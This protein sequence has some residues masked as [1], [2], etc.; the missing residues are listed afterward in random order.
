[1]ARR[2]TKILERILKHM[3]KSRDRDS[4]FSDIEEIYDDIAERKGNGYADLWYI[5]QII[6]SLFPMC[7]NKIYRS[8]TMFKNYM[9]IT[10]RNILKHKGYSFINIAG[11]AVG[12][13]CCLLTLQW[14]QYEYSY[15][16]FHENTDDLY[17][18]VFHAPDFDAYGDV[19][20]GLAADFLREEYPEIT[21]STVFGRTSAKL[22][23]N[24]TDFNS[25]G[26]YIHDDFLEMFT[27]PIK[28]GDPDRPFLQRNS[29]LLTEDL[30]ERL[31]GEEDPL[32]KRVR[33]ND[34]YVYVV[35]GILTDIPGNSELQ[36]DYLLS[37]EI[38]PGAMKMWD[39]KWPE[40]Y[41]QLDKNAD[42]NEIDKKI[43]DVYNDHNPGA[44]R[45]DFLLKPLT[46][47][48]LYDLGGGG[49]INYIYVYSAMA[50]VILVIA[51]FNYMNLATARSLNRLNEIGIKKVVGSTR[52]QLIKQFMSESL[53]LTFIAFLI[54]FV[55]ANLLLPAVNNILGRQI[56]VSISKEFIA[57]SV[58]IFLIT[59]L[60]AGS[61]PALFLSSFSPQNI[62][63]GSVFGGGKGRGGASLLR[64]Y[65]VTVQYSLSIIFVISAVVI[66]KQL[67]FMKNTNLGFKKDNVLI[68]QTPGVLGIKVPVLKKELS[69]R[70]DILSTSASRTSIVR[71]GSS[72]GISWPGKTDNVK[73]FDVIYNLVDY[74]YLETFGLEVVEGRFL[75]EEYPTD[76]ED[77]FV[78]NE[79]CVRAMGIEDPIGKRITQGPGTQFEDSREVVGVI[80]DY[81]NRSLHHEIRPMLFRYAERSS[82]LNI[83]LKPDNIQGTISFIQEKVEESAP[84]SQFNYWFL[85]DEIDNLYRTEQTIGVFI[86]YLTVLAI[87]ISSL[88]LLGLTSYTVQ[89]RVK[90]VGIR[91][92]YGAP[93]SSIVILFSKDFTKW[94]IL[95]NIIAWPIANYALNRWLQS[96]AYQTDIGIFIF[97]AAGLIA[98]IIAILTIVSQTIKAANSNPVKSLRYE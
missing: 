47:M 44:S 79:A 49:L 94:I 52:F 64:K 69:N 51:C 60:T 58:G 50:V 71:W 96:F 11:L 62:L 75:S 56:A 72:M 13:A 4:I 53:I 19:L 14:I 85:D 97:L 74:D 31:Y 78:I 41:V 3:M 9:K 34:R 17:R 36:F 1:M 57:A 46:E 73:P 16:R 37:Y 39:N 23:F 77:G 55:M 8:A 12:I 84:S 25:S 76:A 89:Q 42:F 10:W 88:G 48:H 2:I 35:S 54:A 5:G 93:V 40:V 98:L 68:V 92:V 28:E 18:V 81:H 38:A 70:P 45:N 61:Y 63:K 32:G 30:A 43:V 27:F 66:F 86:I 26:A 22:S 6:K 83:K 24:R 15:D 65:L 90:E 80:K 67:N 21:H 95:S 33:L 20:P 82:F 29:I 7:R 87:F 91:K 59:G